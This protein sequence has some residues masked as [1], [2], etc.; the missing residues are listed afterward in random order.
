MEAADP[1]WTS[2]G[3]SLVLSWGRGLRGVREYGRWDG[4]ETPERMHAS[5]LT[6]GAAPTLAS[7]PPHS[8]SNHFLVQTL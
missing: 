4:R 5:P 2:L 6:G 7:W 1:E 3:V 8:P